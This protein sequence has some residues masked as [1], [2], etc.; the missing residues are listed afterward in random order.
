LT[1]WEIQQVLEQELNRLVDKYRAPLLLCCVQGRTRDEAAQQLGWSL[2]VLRGRLDRGRHLLRTRLARRGIALAVALAPLAVAGTSDAAVRPALISS[3]VRSALT[4]AHSSVAA[5]AVSAQ[6]ATLVQGVIQAMFLAKRKVV[7][8]VFL[9]LA[10]LCAG[11]G[12]ATYRAQAQDEPA[13]PTAAR[14]QEADP[15]LRGETDVAKLQ[16]EIAR[17][18]L[19]LEQTRL[20]LK[21]ANQEILDLRAAK[22]EG[23]NREKTRQ[24]E[25]ILKKVEQDVDRKEFER[26]LKKVEQDRTGQGIHLR[27]TSPDGKLIAA[28]QG[29]SFGL[30]DAATGKEIRRFEGHTDTVRSLAFSPDGK[31]LVSASTDDVG[32]LWDIQ[33]GKA[34]HKFTH[35]KPLHTVAFSPDGK[36]LLLG[37]NDVRMEID[38]ATGKALRVYKVPPQH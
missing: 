26:I 13:G 28:A 9:S 37:A 32:L 18:R 11:A 24:A 15:P 22:A 8:I 21:V 6:T 5:A 12:V 4:A 31:T 33:T 34:L 36:H 17:L 25:E 27:V 20:L 3:T 35:L 30:F 29:K 19:E 14:G 1:G 38:V 16:R 10:F 7:A 2:G 23:L